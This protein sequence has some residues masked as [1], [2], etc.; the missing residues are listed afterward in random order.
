MKQVFILCALF[1]ASLF[2]GSCQDSPTEATHKKSKSNVAI[3][4]EPSAEPARK[5]NKLYL[6]IDK[7]SRP[8]VSKTGAIL[9][10]DLEGNEIK[11][12]LSLK[13][14]PIYQ[15]V[16]A[17]SPD[18]KRLAVGRFKEI[19]LWD[20]TLS[21]ITQTIK[22]KAGVRYLTFHPDGK[23]LAVAGTKYTDPATIKIIGDPG[24]IKIFDIDKGKVIQVFKAHVKGI[25]SL[26]FHP[27]G[28]RLA[29]TGR[30]SDVSWTV[31]LWDM[32]SGENFWTFKH[33]RDIRCVTFSPDGKFLAS[34]GRA[35]FLKDN[36]V[37][38]AIHL[39]DFSADKPDLLWEKG[40]DLQGYLL[41]FSS[42]GKKLIV[43]GVPRLYLFA[44]RVFDVK[45][46]EEIRQIDNSR[47][48]QEIY[49][50]LNSAGVFL[51]AVVI[52]KGKISPIDVLK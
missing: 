11:E 27:D 41:A 6:A 17:L 24:V 34:S 9:L 14:N 47:R 19:V 20:I 33:P 8:A 12:T 32:K 46:G 31:K 40:N 45:T 42:D 26:S 43:D 25:N 22:I 48:R 21:K 3:D 15:R 38:G 36:S 49:Y 13:G 44:T 39:W 30:D 35:I 1:M 52:N 23:R 16:V 51:R 29:S 5:Q 4:K 50:V 7:Y 2:I 28:K 10:L 37:K 18:G